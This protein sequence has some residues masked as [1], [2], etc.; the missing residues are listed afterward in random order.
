MRGSR[1]RSLVVLAALALLPASS[2]GQGYDPTVYPNSWALVIGINEYYRAPRLSYAVADALSVSAL[3]PELGFPRGNIRLLLDNEATKSRIESVLYRE[4]ARMGP[5]DR[6]FV[7][8]AGHGETFQIRGGEEGYILPV[9]AD[10]N[11]LPL[12]GI[13]M[14]DVRRISQRMKGKHFLFVMDACFS[15]FAVSRE[16]SPP[17]DEYLQSVMKEPAVQVLTAGRKG[18]QALEEGGHGVFTKHLLAGL[19]GLADTQQRGFITASQLAWWLE[20]RVSRDSRGRMTPQFG[21]L[22]GEGQFVFKVGLGPVVASPTTRPTDEQ[23]VKPS[24]PASGGAA[25]AAAP[26]AA[27]DVAARQAQET[28][29]AE[30]RRGEIDAERRKVEAE[31]QRLANERALLEAQRRLDAERRALED[32]RRKTEPSR[33]PSETPRGSDKQVAALPP[34]SA[35]ASVKISAWGYEAVGGMQ[36]VI[37]LGLLAS[38]YAVEIDGRPVVDWH[39]RSVEETVVLEAGPHTIK[40]LSR[41]SIARKAR[42]VFERTLDLAAG[43]H[44]V[45]INFVL[46]SITINGQEGALK[47]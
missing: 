20:D 42:V 43:D 9:D 27:P 39:I 28:A 30:R 19:R 29:D 25:A 35:K 18:Q 21:R 44:Q 37:S 40:V 10:P 22:E 6:L 34:D 23:P 24:S 47:F 5:D 14:E 12:T 2:S 38:E 33:P 17:K 8:F 7:Y 45:K 32:E 41:H 31:F 3:L 16:A 1:W 13:P 26:P 46:Q 4:F 36:A 15:G 11:M